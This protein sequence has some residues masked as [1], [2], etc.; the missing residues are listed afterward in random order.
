MAAQ[1]YKWGAFTVIRSRKPAGPESLANI[2]K[3]GDNI[4]I[5][6]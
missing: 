4:L 3:T 5:F 1:G 6:E 2:L